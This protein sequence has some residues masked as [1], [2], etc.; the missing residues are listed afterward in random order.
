MNDATVVHPFVFDIGPLSLT[1]FGLAVLA[2]FVISQII[3][4]RELARRGHDP[5]PIPDLI[6]AAVLGTLIGGKL[7]YSLV[8]THDF[9]DLFSRA[10]VGLWGGFLGSV[11]ACYVRRKAKEQGLS[12]IR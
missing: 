5:T 3:A 6:L 10:G 12:R 4:Q 11:A 9:R 1:G 7:Y 8:I 2:A